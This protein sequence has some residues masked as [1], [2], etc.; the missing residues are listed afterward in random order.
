MSDLEA[1]KQAIKTFEDG[2]NELSS[3]MKAMKFVVECAL[4]IKRR[5]DNG[6]DREVE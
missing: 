3:T 2:K 6:Q 4:V 5:S 1:L